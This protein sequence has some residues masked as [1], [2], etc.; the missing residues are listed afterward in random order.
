MIILC[1][2][3]GSPLTAKA[4][5]QPQKNTQRNPNSTSDVCVIIMTVVQ[6][7]TFRFCESSQINQVKVVN[8]VWNEQFERENLKIKLLFAQYC[9]TDIVNLNS[10][11][12]VIEMVSPYKQKLIVYT[13]CRDSSS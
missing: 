4:H 13:I 6:Q 10:M 3:F 1:G 5:T 12:F 7:E 9:S 2:K 8:S 11:D